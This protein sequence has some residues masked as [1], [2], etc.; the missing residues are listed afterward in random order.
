MRAEAR[1]GEVGFAGDDV[2]G[3]S[4]DFLLIGFVADFGA[5]EDEGG[6]GQG[7][8]QFGYE[9]QRGRCVPDVNTDADDG[10]LL[11]DNRR[12]NFF[13]ALIDVELKDAGARL[14]RAEIG[15]QIAQSKGGVCPAGVEGG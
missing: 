3:E 7:A 4:A 1:E 5:A 13:D 2:I 10:G 11:G 12:H 6:S 15:H 8:F 14:E 9:L